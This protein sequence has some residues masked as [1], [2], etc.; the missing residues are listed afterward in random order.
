M[1][2]SPYLLT[3]VIM[4]HYLGRPFLVDFTHVIHALKL[5]SRIDCGPDLIKHLSNSGN[6]AWLGT[7]PKLISR[8]CAS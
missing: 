1:P 5:S 2:C 3:A 4:C 8:I 7:S 6:I